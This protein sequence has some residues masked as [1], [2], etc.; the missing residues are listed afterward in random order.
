MLSC[1]VALW[2]LSYHASLYE[3]GGTIMQFHNALADTKGFC[4]SICNLVVLAGPQYRQLHQ[5]TECNLCLKEG[6]GESFTKTETDLHVSFVSQ[7]I[8]HHFMLRSDWFVPVVHSRSYIVRIWS[9]AGRCQDVTTGY[10]KINKSWA[11]KAEIHT[12]ILQF[13]EYSKDL[14]W[15]LNTSVR[16]R[17]ITA[18]VLTIVWS[19]KSCHG[20]KS[21]IIQGLCVQRK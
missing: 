12:N 14:T 16:G 21:F 18:D 20:C 7:S 9:H 19:G 17:L 6:S 15:L 10:E 5:G 11:T 1:A 4:F 3:G 13:G 2:I 8:L